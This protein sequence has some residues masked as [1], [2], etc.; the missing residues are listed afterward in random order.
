MP[1]IRMVDDPQDPDSNSGDDSGGGGGGGFNSGGGGGGLFGIIMLLLGLFRGR[2]L[3][4]LLVIV[5]GGYFFF[6]RTGCGS[7]A[8]Q[9]VAQ[10]LTTGGYLDPKQ[11]EKANIYESLS[12]DST[13]NPLPEAVN[14]QKYAPAV[15]DQGHQGSCVAWSSAYGA[16]TI[17]EAA[18]TGQDP[19]TLKYS[20]SF[21]YNQIGLENCQGSYI[22]KAMEFMTKSGSVPYTQ[23]PYDDQDC[24]RQ[25]DQQLLNLARQYKMRGFNRLTPGDRNNVID[26]H[27]IK[28]NIS[29]G[30]P[31]VIGMMVGGSYMQPMFGQDVWAPTAED[32]QMMGFGGHAQ[33]VVGYDDRK[34]GG[35]FLIMNSWS[36]K[37]GNNGFA[38]VRYPDFK[39]FV[40][41]AYG[42]EPMEKTGAAAA[43]PFACEIGLV[44]VHYEGKKTLSG[45]YIPLQVKN[46][47]VFETISPVKRG[48][49]FKMEV[50][51]STECYVYVFG[52]ET[53]G[54]SYT[55][56][57]YPRTDIPTKTKYSPFCGITGYRLFPKDK[58]LMPDSIGTRDQ[59]AVV[60]SKQPLDWYGI[61]NKLSQ[62]AGQDYSARLNAALASQLIHNVKFKSS[63][64]GNMQFTVDGD[65]NSAV[66]T[67]VEISKQ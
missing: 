36:S 15:G 62:D 54:T 39:Y 28:E 56:F 23:F 64:K 46:G 53:D 24:S 12:D 30:A 63:A 41:E 1:P 16:R 65:A 57:P 42:L 5:I 66:A 50:R 45:D 55:L 11:F 13:K 2:G 9:Q 10:Q 21:L 47:N 27:A 59:M 43:A 3:I 18:R 29:Q 44:Q 8:I 58:S 48:T 33:C 6:G 60:V 61:N 26:L 31:V 37:W 34:Y 14:L 19:N 32:R 17:A 25:P 67:I 52:K 49:R 35:A 22:E 51:N 38:W 4:F 7:A 40:R 20:P